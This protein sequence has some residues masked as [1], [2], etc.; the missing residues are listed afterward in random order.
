MLEYVMNLIIFVWGDFFMNTKGRAISEPTII[1]IKAG[2]DNVE[3]ALSQF[4]EVVRELSIRNFKYAEIDQR[5]PKDLS[6]IKSK[7]YP[8]KFRASG[9]IIIM[10]S[11]VRAGNHDRRADAMI[12][13]LRFAGFELRPTVIQAIYSNPRL[14]AYIWNSTSTSTSV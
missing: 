9:N 3:F 10:I 12:E 2:P 11:G 13:I 7:M 4:K 1:K 8:L 5:L 6:E 14:K